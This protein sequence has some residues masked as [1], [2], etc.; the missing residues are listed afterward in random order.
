MAGT[1]T[2]TEAQVGLICESTQISVA[3][4]LN[5]VEG[6]DIKSIQDGATCYVRDAD[7]S[8]RFF[9]DSLDAPSP[10]VILPASISI[11]S[12]GRW[13]IITAGT[14]PSG[15]VDSVQGEDG[16]TPTTP[17][18]GT[19]VLSGSELYARNGTNGAML[20]NVDMGSNS[21]ENGNNAEFSGSVTANDFNGVELTTLGAA[22]SFLNEQGDYITI[23]PGGTD[24]TIQNISTTPAAITDTLNTYSRVDTATIASPSSI[25]L[26]PPA[27]R[28][29]QKME[30]YQQ[31]IL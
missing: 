28:M 8:F 26:P 5:S 9:E 16:I 24:I 1:K 29:Y 19:V 12:P 2:R 6:I 31:V 4:V 22:D 17:Q 14:P 21:I 18:T 30:K 25:T 10:T 27:K 7:N 23:T 20:A 3:G 11:S 15:G 13:I